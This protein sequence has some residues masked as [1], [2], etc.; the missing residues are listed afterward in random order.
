MLVTFCICL[1][2]VVLLL[3]PLTLDVVVVHTINYPTIYYLPS[4]CLRL[5]PDTNILSL[6]H[7]ASFVRFVSFLGNIGSVAQ[8]T[9]LCGRTLGGKGHV[10][11]FGQHF[12]IAPFHAQTRHRENRKEI[13]DHDNF[14]RTDISIT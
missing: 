6:P 2:P 8:S 14:L 7:T 12:A 9:K 5:F 11:N 13:R 10:L 4:T 1:F 3:L